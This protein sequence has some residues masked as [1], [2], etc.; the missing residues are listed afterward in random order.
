MGLEGGWKGFFMEVVV[1]NNKNSSEQ[2]A[3]YSC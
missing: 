3:G 2:K 1:H